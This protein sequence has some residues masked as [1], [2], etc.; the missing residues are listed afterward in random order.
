MG[1]VE[2][3]LEHFN[4]RV[5]DYFVRGAKLTHPDTVTQRDT[6]SGANLLTNCIH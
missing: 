2:G 4:Q 1:R 6:S 3:L 5:C